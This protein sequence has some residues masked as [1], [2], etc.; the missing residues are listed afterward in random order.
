LSRDVEELELGV[1]LEQGKLRRFLEASG[2]S[3]QERIDEL[4]K[5]WCRVWRRREFLCDMWNAGDLRGRALRSACNRIGA[6][7]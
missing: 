2:F 1:E 3:K 7:A 6:V 5:L 4:P